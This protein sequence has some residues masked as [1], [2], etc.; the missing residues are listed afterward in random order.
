MTRAPT[1]SG[2]ASTDRLPIRSMPFCISSVKTKRGSPRRSRRVATGARSRTATPTT[3]WPRGNTVSRPI[4]APVLAADGEGHERLGFRVDSVEAR[5]MHAEQLAHAVGDALRDQIQIERLGQQPA[6]IGQRAHPLR[7]PGRFAIEPRVVDRVRRVRGQRAEQPHL[8]G[9]VLATLAHADGENPENLRPIRAARSRPRSRRR[10]ASARR[11]ASADRAGASTVTSGSRF[12][13]AVPT[14]PRR[15]ARARSRWPG[16]QFPRRREGR[17]AG[18]PARRARAGAALDPKSS[19]AASTTRRNTSS[20]DKVAV[21]VCAR[22]PRVSSRRLFSRPS[23]RSAARATTWP[24]WCATASSRVS[25]SA[26]K[27]RGSVVMS[28][29]TPH[30]SPFT[31]IG[32]AS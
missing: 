1:R 4:A 9:R 27:V 3:A 22:R 12:A 2:T 10:R 19:T 20:G 18:R 31:G 29:I 21:S 30:V 15:R 28:A 7:L 16:R 6:E 25:S 8:V 13:T 5:R 14:A 26:S 11:C 17:R 24:T 23:A 32:S